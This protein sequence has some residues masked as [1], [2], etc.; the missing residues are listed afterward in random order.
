MG[1]TLGAQMGGKDAY[2]ATDTDV[3]ALRRLLEK[4]CRS[5]YSSVFDE[6]ALILRIDGSI[7]S[8]GKCGVE[9]VRLQRKARYAMA[10]IYVPRYVWSADN[11]GNFRRF[12]A[13]EVESAVQEIAERARKAK[14]PVRSDLLL[15]DVR[16]ATAT[17][18]A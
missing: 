10:E 12:L 14:V 2:A 15:R 4:E 3:L 16:R 18:L 17:L 8:W 13:S 5:S 9:H 6:F 1:V 11:P 7:E